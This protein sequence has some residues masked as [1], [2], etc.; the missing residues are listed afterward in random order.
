MIY[1]YWNPA[2]IMIT[3]VTAAVILGLFAWLVR[4]VSWTNVSDPRWSSILDRNVSSPSIPPYAI[5]FGEE[6]RPVPISLRI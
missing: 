4:L 2:P 1:D 6:S 5:I 3:A